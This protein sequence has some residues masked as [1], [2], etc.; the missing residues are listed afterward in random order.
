MGGP[1]HFSGLSENYSVLGANWMF[2]TNASSQ[3][4]SR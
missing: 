4:N 2:Y 3:Y 1:Q